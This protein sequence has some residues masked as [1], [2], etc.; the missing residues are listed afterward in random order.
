L[1][2]GA[3]DFFAGGVAGPRDF[4]SIRFRSRYVHSR[5]RRGRIRGAGGQIRVAGRLF[6]Q[7]TGGR[8]A[9]I[10]RRA[11]AAGAENRPTASGGGDAGSKAEIGLVAI[12]LLHPEL[13]EEIAQSGATA[14]FE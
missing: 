13:R 11:A 2:A 14:N 3:G 7:R 10:D 1:D 4:Y 6:S 5:A 9:R 8:G 12:A